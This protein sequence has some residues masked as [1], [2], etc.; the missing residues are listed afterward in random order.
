MVEFNIKMNQK[1]HLA[2][3]PQELAKLLGTNIKAS[4]NCIAVLMYPEGAK[5]EDILRSLE[6]I[7]L[8]LEHKIELRKREVDAQ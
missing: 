4:A 2:Y 1:Q 3:I 6:I 8:D 5:P 7:K